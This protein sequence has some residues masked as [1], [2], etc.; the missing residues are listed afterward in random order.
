MC[1]NA[2]R[3]LWIAKSCNKVCPRLGVVRLSPQDVVQHGSG[4]DRI[5]IKENARPRELIADS[6]GLGGDCPAVVRD[7]IGRT[8]CLQ[9]GFADSPIKHRQGDKSGLA[10]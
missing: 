6:H 8:C 3:D 9:Q 5:S 2:G 1:G 4:I 7:R 10:V